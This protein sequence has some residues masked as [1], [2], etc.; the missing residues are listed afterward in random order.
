MATLTAARSIAPKTFSTAT[1]SNFFGRS[2]SS[3]AILRWS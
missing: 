3:A 2:T 1:A